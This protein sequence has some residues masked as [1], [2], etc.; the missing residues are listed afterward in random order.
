MTKPLKPGKRWRNP[1]VPRFRTS[2]VVLST[3]AAVAVL[4]LSGVAHAHVTVEPDVAE[5]GG[6]AVLTFRVPTEREDASTTEVRVTFPK[7]QPVGSVRTTPVPGW[8]IAT[9]TRTL[10][11][12]IDMFGEPVREVVTQVTW[13]ATGPGIAPGQFQ[14][15]DVSLGPL[16]PSGE[17]A[18]HA[19]QTYS[20]GEE[21]NWNQVAVGDSVEPEHPAP[22]LTITAPAGDGTADHENP[23]GTKTADE[24]SPEAEL[25]SQVGA[26]GDT[27]PSAALAVG[28]SGA[29]L[30]VSVAALVLAW[31]RRTA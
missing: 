7:D 18:F 25:A 16:P 9:K 15:F 14:D 19:L 27:G 6:F 4:M 2:S 31:K 5:G 3:A 12:P 13:T 22:V 17:M 8:R 26:T 10:D 20:S 24:G 11:E 21:V 1:P 30:V 28:L 23:A 29:A